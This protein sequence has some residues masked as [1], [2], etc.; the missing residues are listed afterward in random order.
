MMMSASL[1]DAA[2][3][4]SDAPN[5]DEA[6][7]GILKALHRTTRAD[8]IAILS[9]CHDGSL[10]VA[11]HMGLSLAARGLCFR[12]PEHPRLSHSIDAARPVR[13]HDPREPDP[14]DG[15][16]A[17]SGGPVDPIHACLATPLFL[18]KKLVGVLTMDA[19]DPRGLDTIADNDVQIVAALA[20][21]ALG[22]APLSL[23]LPA[24]VESG[25]LIGRS[26]AMMRLAREIEVLAPR[27]TTVLITGETGTGK[28]LVARALHERSSRS[29]SPLVVVN[30]AAL[31]AHLV[32]S[33]LFG[34]AKGAFTGAATARAGRFEAA[35]GSTIFLDEV[36][37]L[38]LAAQAQLLR[39]LQEG[40]IQR[41]GE[42][43]PRRVDVRVIAAT[44]RDLWR[45]VAEGRFRVDLLH[46]LWVYPIQV[47]P[48]REREGDV[49]LLAEHFARTSATKLGLGDVLLHADTLDR[50]TRH[51][52]PGNVRELEHAIE[53]A[54]LRRLATTTADPRRPLMLR[55]EDLDLGG[56]PKPEPQAAETLEQTL[57]RARRAAFAHA[58]DSARG[59][60]AEAARL[61]GLSR[62]FAYKEGLRLGLI[63]GPK[64]RR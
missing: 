43:R 29:G 22:H 15:L 32:E 11:A 60:A 34:H 13:F 12:P 30:C 38:P 6:L 41:L 2:K 64:G 56:Q 37:E 14:Y 31:P 23:P 54:I 25:R 4:L 57:D 17:G 27:P 20:A 58:F 19:L 44:N 18:H 55:L 36:G 3:S 46:R 7:T 16:L 61:L 49:S 45:E 42:D 8:V 21:S 33:E 62:S 39:T 35:N 63:Q 51:A 5:G 50:L 24:R 52:W 9:R 26:S 48:L 40:E 1:L 10:Q 28:E 47:A 59:N 53:R